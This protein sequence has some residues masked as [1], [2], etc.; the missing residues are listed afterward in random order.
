MATQVI[1]VAD[2]VNV[3]AGLNLATGSTYL[4]EARDAPVELFEVG[5]ANQ[6]AA[7]AAALP[8]DG[9]VLHPGTIRRAADRLEH[10]GEADEWLYARSSG[11]AV[12]VVSDA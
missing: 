1:A 3:T 11:A 9:V 5:A 4:L 7:D 8:S 6:A 2:R 12:L 10:V